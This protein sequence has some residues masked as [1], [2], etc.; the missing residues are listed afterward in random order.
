MNLRQEGT[1]PIDAYY[2][3]L[4]EIDR[5]QLIVDANLHQY[6]RHTGQPDKKPKSH[7]VGCTQLKMI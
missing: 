6:Y 4:H 5:Q 1:T 7:D 2:K 3:Y